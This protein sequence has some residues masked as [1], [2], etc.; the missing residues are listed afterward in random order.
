VPR[1]ERQWRIHNTAEMGGVRMA[2][3]SCAALL[4]RAMVGTQG[5]V[6]WREHGSC[7]L[8]LPFPMQCTASYNSF[9]AS[10]R[11]RYRHEQG[12]K[13]T[14]VCSP[15][16]CSEASQLLLTM[17]PREKSIRAERLAQ[18]ERPGPGHQLKA[19][20]C[21]RRRTPCLDHPSWNQDSK[22]VLHKNGAYAVTRVRFLATAPAA[23]AG[24]TSTLTRVP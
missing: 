22:D 6:L 24:F 9:N 7:H 3:R 14:K 16:T 15:A 20:P 5:S 21:L 10:C 18:I 4:E 23:S 11:F 13:W 8:P 19:P 12:K 1:V 2:P 17:V